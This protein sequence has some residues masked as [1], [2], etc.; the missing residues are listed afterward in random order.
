MSSLALSQPLV[1]L[2][3]RSDSFNGCGSFRS[4]PTLTFDL[5]ENKRRNP[6]SETIVLCVIAIKF[7]ILCDSEEICFFICH[8]FKKLV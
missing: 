5:V 8:F 2:N 6:A 3:A 7:H 4:V 1:I